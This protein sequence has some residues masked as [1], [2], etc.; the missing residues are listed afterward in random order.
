MYVF[1]GIGLASILLKVSTI[2]SSMIYASATSLATSLTPEEVA[3]GRLYPAI[4]RIRDVSVVVARGVVREAQR[5]GVDA[6]GMWWLRDLND[7]EI[8]AWIRSKMYDPFVAG[9][10]EVVG[11]GSKL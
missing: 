6:A 7:A 10:G 4:E 5:C 11:R 9:V 1:P 2:T 8:D 3:E